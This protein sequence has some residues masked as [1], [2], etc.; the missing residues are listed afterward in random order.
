MIIADSVPMNKQSKLYMFNSWFV[1]NGDKPPI[2]TPLK[3]NVDTLRGN[4][5]APTFCRALLLIY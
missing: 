2:P 1:T 3:N 4:V 5:I